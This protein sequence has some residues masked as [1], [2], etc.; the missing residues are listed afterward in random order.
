MSK[1]AR[2]NELSASYEELLRHP[3]RDLFTSGGKS[4]HHRKAEL[5]LDYFRRHSMDTSRLA[6]LDLGCGKGELLACL[7]SHFVRIA[8]CDVSAEMM[9]GIEGVETRIQDDAQRI[10]F[11]DSTFDFITAVCVYHHVPPE[12]RLALSREVARVL[13]PGGVL[14]VVE[15]NPFNPVT[16]LIVSRTPVDADAILLQPGETRRLMRHAS[17][18]VHEQ[19]YF[20]Y[21]PVG[22]YQRIPRVERMLR[23]IP[24]GG[25]YAVFGRKLKLDVA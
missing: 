4:F 23:G 22:L 25:Q 1:E 3:I 10:P 9:K 2:F 14:A 12:N 7:R 11:P 21:F 16:R 13:K 19:E 24:F 20:L 5:I 8:G 17:L 6:Y 15:H 18:A